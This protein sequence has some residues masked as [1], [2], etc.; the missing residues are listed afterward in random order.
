MKQKF[1]IKLKNL[2]IITLNSKNVH[3]N[4]IDRRYLSSSKFSGSYFVKLKSYLTW[5]FTGI[6]S[7]G[8]VD[9]WP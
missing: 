8:L 3:S 5:R 1:W 7:R 4:Q 9:P 2:S 6:W